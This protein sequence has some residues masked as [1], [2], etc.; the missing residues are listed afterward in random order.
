MADVAHRDLTGADIHEP[1]GV[2]TAAA[3]EVYAADGV[4]S[5]SWQ[6]VDSLVGAS[7]LTAV[8]GQVENGELLPLPPGFTFAQCAYIVSVAEADTSSGGTAIA[9]KCYVDGTGVVICQRILPDDA[10]VG[11]DVDLT[12][13]YLTIGVG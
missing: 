13:N 11:I 8:S 6:S 2:E 1:K 7:T 9:F 10:G 4:G 3:D 5:G 12:A